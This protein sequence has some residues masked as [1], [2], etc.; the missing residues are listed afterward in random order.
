MTDDAALSKLSAQY[1]H[2]FDDGDID[3]LL[4]LFEADA[5]VEFGGKRST[6]HDQLATFFAV[7]SAATKG[8]RHLC[9]NHELSIEADS[10]TGISDFMVARAD[11]K[12]PVL[13]RYDDTYRKSAGRW[14]FVSRVIT[15]QA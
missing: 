15:P 1:C 2:R 9:V 14:L 10:A 3:S 8:G 13:G 5:T 12:P 11:G 6:G 7:I 4:Q